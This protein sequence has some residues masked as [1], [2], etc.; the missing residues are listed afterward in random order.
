MHVPTHQQLLD[1]V[2]ELIRQKHHD[3]TNP[4]DPDDPVNDGYLDD[5]NAMLQFTA[6]RW[7]RDAVEALLPWVGSNFNPEAPPESVP[8]SYDYWYDS[9]EHILNEVPV[10][11]PWERPGEGHAAESEGGLGTAD[12]A[13]VMV[14][15]EQWNDQVGTVRTDIDRSKDVLI[16]G[17]CVDSILLWIGAWDSAINNVKDML[18]LEDD[19]KLG[20]GMAEAFIG[21][22]QEK[23]LGEMIDA[24]AAVA[25]PAGPLFV[26]FA[27]SVKEGADK[28]SEARTA[29]RITEFI[30]A[31]RDVV[32]EYR[33]NVAKFKDSFTRQAADWVQY[34]KD[35]P[36][37]ENAQDS[38]WAFSISLVDLDAKL[39]ARVQG[40]A[41]RIEAELATAFVAQ[42]KH[43][44]SWWPFADDVPGYVEIYADVVGGDVFARRAKVMG[45]RA[46]QVIKVLQGTY[47]DGVEVATLPMRK[48][49]IHQSN[50]SPDPRFSKKVFEVGV[51][52]SITTHSKDAAFEQ[53]V[54]SA[55]AGWSVTKDL[56]VG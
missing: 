52:G 32:N 38:Y 43:D 48:I 37:D 26:E 22:V 19:D 18:E 5:W 34:A 28:A 49:Y 9:F 31:Q 17:N 54:L 13:P 55:P 8:E 12:T 53:A 23:A 35:H 39:S 41:K 44:D 11:L 1:E 29:N 56:E 33:E 50:W 10:Q 42:S 40:A 30:V 4:F 14:T 7:A 51:D 36:N 46:E 2:G 27:K 15:H 45:E 16:A 21:W 24:A 47:P 20:D 3:A 6:D 25:A